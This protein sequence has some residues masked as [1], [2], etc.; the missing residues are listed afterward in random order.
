MKKAFI[1]IVLEMH[2]AWSKADTVETGHDP[3]HGVFE[4]L[5]DER[6]D[7]ELAALAWRFGMRLRSWSVETEEKT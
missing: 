3:A 4:F 6:L 1:T 7:H 5:C 2:N